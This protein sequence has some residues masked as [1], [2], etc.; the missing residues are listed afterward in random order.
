MVAADSAGQ[1][2]PVV[3][4]RDPADVENRLISSSSRGGSSRGGSS[5]G[6]S[7]RGGGKPGVR[8]GGGAGEGGGDDKLEDEAAVG[9]I[10]HILKTAFKELYGGGSD[11]QQEEKGQASAVKAA[12]K[13]QGVSAGA[14]G[15][16]SGR[17]SSPSTT[18]SRNAEGESSRVT[19][20]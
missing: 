10:Q 2:Q 20:P 17:R 15:S 14:S 8:S 7:S 16:E 1:Q 19:A 18:G 5:R 6:G 3:A 9:S 4:E 13:W 12:G 11:E